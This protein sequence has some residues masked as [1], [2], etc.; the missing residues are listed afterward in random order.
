MRPGLRATPIVVD[1]ARHDAGSRSTMPHFWQN[2]PKAIEASADRSSRCGCFRG[3]FADLHELQGGEQ[4]THDVLCCR[5]APTASPTHRSTGAGRRTVASRRP[6]WALSSGAV[7][8]LAP[9]RPPTTRRSS[10]P[11]SRAPTAS[12]TSAKRSTS[13]AGGTSARSTATT[14]A[15]RQNEPPP[16]VSHYNNQYD[17]IAGF[18][19][20]VPA[21]RR[22]ALVDAWRRSSPRTSSTSTSITP[23]R[24]KSAYNHGLFWHTY[25]YGDADTATHRTYPRAAK[26]HIHGG[27]PSADHNYTTGLMLHYF[28]TGDEASRQTV[29]RAR[30]SS[31][32]T[33]TTAARRSS[34]G[35]IAATPAARRCR[36]PATTAPAAA[37]R[38][39]STRCSTAH[40]LTGDAAVPRRRP[41]SSS[42]ASI[43]PADD[44]ARRAARR[45]GAALV[46][47]DVPAVARQVP[48]LQGGARRARRDVRVRARQPAALRALDGR[49]RA[50]VSRQ[51]GEARVPDR[52][53]GGAGHP[54]ERRLLFR[55]ACTRRAPSA[56]GSSSARDS[57]TATRST[58][59]QEACR[60]ARSLRPVVVLLSSGFMHGWFGDGDQ[61]VE[62]PPR[63][64]AA[65]GGFGSPEVFVAQRD[66]AKKKAMLI[67]GAGAVAVI[68]LAIF[69]LVR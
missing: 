34:A 3:Q 60:R 57:S 1:L 21:D 30:R 35:S 66:R 64:G 9:P 59:L 48:A 51:A 67:A 63:A 53:L 13:T 65:D 37:R 22:S 62:P 28:L 11:R 49:A 27:G 39:R 4:K 50:S 44:I 68:G 7:P 45:A 33:W 15:V 69:L 17:P 20:S 23:T 5:S 14:K 40:R 42:G 10:T 18:A 12:S 56:I 38:I 58:T 36:R 55:R 29:D 19:L 24:D 54:E 2:F 25:H 46:L 16:L 31:S 47:H 41:S 32:S 6:E 61:A 8:F 52:D 26:G 43:H